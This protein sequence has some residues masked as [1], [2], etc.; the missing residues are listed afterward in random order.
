MMLTSIRYDLSKSNIFKI[1]HRI[2]CALGLLLAAYGL[3]MCIF[4]VLDALDDLQIY[5]DL[6]FSYTLQY[7]LREENFWACAVFFLV[8]TGELVL[9]IFL[10]R[11]A[12]KKEPIS[13]GVWYF[14]T[15][16]AIHAA[17][18][19]NFYLLQIPIPYLFDSD[20]VE[21]LYRAFVEFTTLPS[22]AYFSLYLM[23]VRKHRSKE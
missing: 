23:R 14:G 21:W 4:T 2:T 18:W 22:I 20:D 15:L 9:Y 5:T 8:V 19:I 11:R 17:A 10:C 12:E 1:L 3:L 6:G 16:L 7:F 13:W